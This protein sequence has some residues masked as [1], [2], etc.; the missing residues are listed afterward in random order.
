MNLLERGG[1]FVNPEGPP[2]F[3]SYLSNNRHILQGPRFLLG[4]P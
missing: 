2:R 3:F 1:P 4:S